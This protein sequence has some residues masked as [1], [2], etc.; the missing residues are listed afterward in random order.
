MSVKEAF[1]KA[2]PVDAT[3]AQEIADLCNKAN[4]DPGDNTPA[5][6][7]RR[8][9]RIEPS[10]RESVRASGRGRGRGRSIGRGTV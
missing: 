1:S 7:R 6:S 4:A 8:S 3:T 5:S 2:F 10:G 9:K